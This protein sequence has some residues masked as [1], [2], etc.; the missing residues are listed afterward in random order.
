MQ[1]MI[2]IYMI[3]LSLTSLSGQTKDYA[4]SGEYDQVSFDRFVES[5][6]ESSGLVFFYRPEWI[7]GVTITARGEGLS[8]AEVL[9]QHLKPQGLSWYMDGGNNVFILR[10]S[11]IRLEDVMAADQVREISEAETEDSNETM[12]RKYFGSEREESSNRICGHRHWYRGH[13]G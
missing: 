7:S 3:L 10:N 11:L 13:S 5:L 6:E 8:L 9:N 2:L 4:F 1:R 12:E